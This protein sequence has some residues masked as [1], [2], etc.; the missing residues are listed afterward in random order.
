MHENKATTVDREPKDLNGCST[1]DNRSVKH[2]W[3]R[4]WGIREK[5]ADG[6]RSA[7]E[8]FEIFSRYFLY[9]K[10]EMS[11]R[12]TPSLT[13]SSKSCT[14]RSVLARVVQ[15]Y[16]SRFSRSCLPPEIEEGKVRRTVA[17][18]S[19]QD[20]VTGNNSKWSGKQYWTKGR[21]PLKYNSNLV[22][23]GE[24]QPPKTSRFTSE[25]SSD[26]S[27]TPDLDTTSK[28]TWDLIKRRRTENTLPTNTRHPT[29]SS[30]KH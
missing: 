30:L 7:D 19:R 9:Y 3:P 28:Q 14:K 22:T 8:R 6:M 12:T 25:T 5:S 21:S 27:T 18:G 23:S 13:L 16:H 4:S 24:Q 10:M 2:W 29:N 1:N 17:R 11:S 26:L 15:R 20:M